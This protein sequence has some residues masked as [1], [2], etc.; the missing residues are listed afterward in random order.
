[1]FLFS[2]VAY[3][4]YS[5]YAGIF[6]VFYNQFNNGITNIIRNWVVGD[7][8]RDIKATYNVW[9]VLKTWAVFSSFET[10]SFSSI[11]GLRGE[12]HA[13]L[14]IYFYAPDFRACNFIWSGTQ[15]QSQCARL[16]EKQL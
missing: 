14:D 11:N 13:G 16:I 8:L 5:E 4:S 15:N 6:S 10:I 3:L 9:K 2:Y 1:M 7:I 12:P